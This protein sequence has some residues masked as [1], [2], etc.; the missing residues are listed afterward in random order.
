MDGLSEK[1]F[2]K[3]FLFDKGFE[4]DVFTHLKKNL[5]ENQVAIYD[6]SVVPLNDNQV[7]LLRK[8]GLHK[9][10]S[11]TIIHCYC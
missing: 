6:F 4:F 7:K 3:Q 9:S 8:G 11:I 10:T 2:Q 5:G 1:V